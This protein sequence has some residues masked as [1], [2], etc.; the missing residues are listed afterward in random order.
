MQDKDVKQWL[1]PIKLETSGKRQP[2]LSIDEQIRH[3][4]KIHGIRFDKKGED[5]AK[6]F[7]SKNNYYHKIKSYAQNFSTYTNT[8]HPDYGKFCDLDF[9]YLVEL[10]V[11][12]MYLRRIIIKMSLDIE[13]FLKV[14][15]IN[16]ITENEKEDAYAIVEKF[17]KTITEEKR[18]EISGK[19][20]NYYCERYNRH[21]LIDIPAWELVEVL[22]FGDFIA[23][24]ELYYTFYPNKNSLINNLKPVQWL[25]NAAA[26]NNCIINDLTVPPEPIFE[27]NKKVN[28]FVSTIDGI[29]PLA[30]EK[31]LSNRSMH[32]FVVML[33][34][35]NKVVS[36]EK[37][38]KHTMEDLQTFVDGRMVLNKHYFVKNA[39]LQSNYVFLKKVV[40]YCAS[41]VVY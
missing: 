23:F 19:L 33:Y 10:S 22:S 27:I 6:E 5:S 18:K 16:D 35:Y 32:D 17:L 34:V 1:A 28:R 15:M 30:R 25:R 13:H 41:N 31:K 2:K 3:L 21:R 12:D 29:S 26:H 8:K 24:Y 38:R 11:I 4:S 37:V 40:D 14:Q 9:E 20:S 36:S 39:L 7:L